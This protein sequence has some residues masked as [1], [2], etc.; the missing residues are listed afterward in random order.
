MRTRVPIIRAAGD[1]DRRSFF[2]GGV[3]TWKLKAEDTGG[4]FFLF[5]DLLERGKS[6]P[7]HRHPEADE[8]LYVLDGEILINIDGTETHLGAGAV[9]FVPRGVQHAF[10]VVSD[11]ARLLS[12]QTPGVGQVF[13]LGASEPATGSTSTVDIARV[14]A[15]ARDNGGVELLGPPPFAAVG[16][17]A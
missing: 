10:L 4:D 17:P 15:S 14:Q 6:T 9:S 1:G 12:L 8:T 13:Y 16:G 5:E 3:H 7:L 2:G 11:S